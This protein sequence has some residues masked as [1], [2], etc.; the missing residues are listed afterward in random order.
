MCTLYHTQASLREIYLRL[1]EYI[2]VLFFRSTSKWSC[3]NMSKQNTP[4]S[5]RKCLNFASWFLALLLPNPEMPAA[6]THHP[7]VPAVISVCFVCMWEKLHSLTWS[8]LL[9]PS[10]YLSLS[11]THTAVTHPSRQWINHRGSFAWG[12][13]TMDATGVTSCPAW[14]VVSLCV[15]MCLWM[16]SPFLVSGLSACFRS[17]HLQPEYPP[18]R[19]SIHPSRSSISSTPPPPSLQSF[20]LPRRKLRPL[21]GRAVL[22]SVLRAAASSPLRPLQDKAV[23]ARG[24]TGLGGSSSKQICCNFI[25]NWALNWEQIEAALWSSGKGEGSE[26]GVVGEAGEMIPGSFMSGKVGLL[27]GREPRQGSYF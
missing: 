20:T 9:F 16:V 23:I 4:S 11:H 13:G 15:C 3:H 2:F 14:W 27:S 18:I 21:S 5:Q 24:T 8:L 12:I 10:L 17:P 25:C 7:L 19:P 1:F 26:L 6:C 22:G